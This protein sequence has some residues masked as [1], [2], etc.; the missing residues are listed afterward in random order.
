MKRIYLEF[1]G[2]SWDGMNLCNDSPDTIEVGLTQLTYATTQNA[3][4]GKTV[5]M[6]S[7]YAVRNTGRRGH[8]YTVTHCT[9]MDD[10]ILVRLECRGD[11]PTSRCVRAAKR[12]ILEFEGGYLDG[13]RLDSQSSNTNEALLAV[14]YYC[15]TEEGTI[16]KKFNGMPATPL[17]ARRSRAR[18]FARHSEY[19]VTQRLED[20]ERVVVR[21]QF[22]A[23]ES[24]AN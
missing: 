22:H 10:E 5:V 9:A 14:A 15:V 24:I 20:W 17:L 6:P 11:D 12:I 3:A 2:G 16:G 21:F 1:I 23:N 18:E 7:D 8:E 13:H 4:I 19:G